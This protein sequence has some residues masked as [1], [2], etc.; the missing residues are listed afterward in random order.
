MSLCCRLTWGVFVLCSVAWASARGDEP[1]TALCSIVKQAPV[2]DGVPDEAVWSDVPVNPVRTDHEGKR[3]AEPPMQFRLCTDG[4]WLYRR[5]TGAVG[6]GAAGSR[7]CRH[8]RLR[9]HRR[10]RVPP[11]GPQHHCGPARRDVPPGVAIPPAAH[12]R[13]RCAPA[14]GDPQA[15]PRGP[16][17]ITARRRNLR[18]G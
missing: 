13:A 11:T 16:R 14:G 17:V 1:P 3:P 9:R 12:R 2:L 15:P 10:N 6:S 18:K 5:P 8:C 7:R 4:S